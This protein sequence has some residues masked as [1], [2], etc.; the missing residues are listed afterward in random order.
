MSILFVA[1]EAIYSAINVE[2][3]DSIKANVAQRAS[4]ARGM[5][6]GVKG[7]EDPV[8]NRLLA[9]LALGLC[10]LPASPLKRKSEDV[11]LT[12]DESQTCTC[13]RVGW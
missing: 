3:R 12:L 11:S 8:N 7:S 10:G 4:E 9:V 2:K 6:R 1:V 13:G 5:E